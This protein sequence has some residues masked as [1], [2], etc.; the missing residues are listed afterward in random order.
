MSEGEFRK[1]FKELDDSKDYWGHER[2][3]LH[4]ILNIL[5]DAKKEAPAEDHSIVTGVLTASQKMQLEKL[6]GYIN[7]LEAFIIKWF[8]EAKSGSY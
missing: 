5:D 2:I 4:E 6:Y 7:N 1:K 8:G 3:Y